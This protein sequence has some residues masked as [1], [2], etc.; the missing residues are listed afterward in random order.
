V[1][2]ESTP[3]ESKDHKL[4][5][6]IAALELRLKDKDRQLKANN[7]LLDEMS[8]RL[9]KQDEQSV[10]KEFGRLNSCLEHKKK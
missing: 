1:N 2:I 10:K 4:T 8:D 6:Q 7:Q 9:S 5:Q 3:Q